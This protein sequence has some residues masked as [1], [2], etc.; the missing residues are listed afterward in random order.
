MHPK[1]FVIGSQRIQCCCTRHVKAV[2][3]YDRHW[4][5][6]ATRITNVYAI[7]YSR[8]VCTRDSNTRQ[9][10][11]QLTIYSALGTRSNGRSPICLCPT[12]MLLQ[13]IHAKWQDERRFTYA[14]S[15]F[16]HPIISCLFFSHISS[17]SCRRLRRADDKPLP[18]LWVRH[19]ATLT[20]SV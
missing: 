1:I 3:E 13:F 11:K 7:N 9:A 8:S 10:K 2:Q 17:S 4:R 18:S 16:W 12:S 15:S 19:T 5:R 6:S 20:G 14:T